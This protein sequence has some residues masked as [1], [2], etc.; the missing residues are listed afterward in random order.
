[1]PNLSVQERNSVLVVDSRLVAANLDI[2]HK[3]VLATIDKY[4]TK[5][6]SSFGAVAFETREFKTKQGNRSTERIAR[7]TEEQATLL[8]T[9]SRNTERVVECKIATTSRRGEIISI[10]FP[11]S[12]TT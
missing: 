1:M 8:M 11:S 4:L 2:K 6:E 12:P 5:I 10:L 7:F 9:F 3:N